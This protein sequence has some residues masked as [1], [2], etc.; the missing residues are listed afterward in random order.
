MPVMAARGEGRAA[1]RG[2]RPGMRDATSVLQRCA[3]DTPVQVDAAQT[4]GGIA[5]FADRPTGRRAC[6][7][8]V[9]RPDSRETTVAASII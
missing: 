9:E 8:R 3:V 1:E 2:V 5:P 7:E 6:S 4:R